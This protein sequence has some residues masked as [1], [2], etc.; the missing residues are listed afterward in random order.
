MWWT[1]GANGVLVINTKKGAKGKISFTFNT[2]AEVKKEANTY[3]LLNA[4]QYVSL[5]QDAL[6]NTISDLGYSSCNAQT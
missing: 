2:S 1:K 3:P 5:M 4:A 6:W